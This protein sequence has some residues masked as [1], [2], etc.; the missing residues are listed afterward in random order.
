MS[1]ARLI[2]PAILAL[3]PS[4]L[5]PAPAAAQEADPPGPGRGR[6]LPF[7]EPGPQHHGGAGCR[8]WT[9][10]RP[11]RQEWYIGFASG[12][13]LANHEP[14]GPPGSP[15]FDDQENASIGD[16]GA[17]ALESQRD[18][19]G[20]GGA[21]EPAVVS[22]RRRGSSARWTAA[23]PGPTW[24]SRTP[25]TSGRSW[26]TP[27]TPTWRG[28]R[29]WGASGG[30]TR[31]AASTTPRTAAPP[32]RKVLYIDED[33]GA[34]DL[35]D[36]PVGPPTPSFAAMYQRRRTAFGLQR[37]RGWERAVPDAGRGD[38]AGREL[39]NGLPEGDKGRIG[40]DI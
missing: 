4:L 36:A 23:A 32:G 39:T 30:P 5:A 13:L 20:D 26:C 16:G 10:T 2:L 38:G 27:R 6:P 31:S 1:F 24:G 25:T 3:G 34:I 22:L 15:L 8:S 12:G 7:R 37:L 11:V 18:L 35:V 33:T 40:L 21:P 29:R 19:G 9:C 28:W 17:G 14:T